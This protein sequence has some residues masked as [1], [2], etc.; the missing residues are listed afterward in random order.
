MFI[1]FDYHDIKYSNEKKV[2]SVFNIY[3][4]FIKILDILIIFDLI[5]SF[6]FNHLI[7]KIN[8]DRQN[9]I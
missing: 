8:L 6:N 9:F 4:G 3:K 2:I 1:Q 5:I 7:F